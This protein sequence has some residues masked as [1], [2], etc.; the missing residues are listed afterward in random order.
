VGII[1]WFGG[2]FIFSMRISRQVKY[3]LFTN[4]LTQLNQKINITDFWKFSGNKKIRQLEKLLLTWYPAQHVSISS[5]T[6]INIYIRISG[7]I[8][9]YGKFV[10]LH[11]LFSFFR[12]YSFV[13][14][15]LPIYSRHGLWTR[16][17]FVRYDTNKRSYGFCDR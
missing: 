3:F 14:A 8:E 9:T 2:K 16:K 4:W 11:N 7:L 17:I 12:Y 6:Y 10:M 1:P 15:V 13:A 5:N